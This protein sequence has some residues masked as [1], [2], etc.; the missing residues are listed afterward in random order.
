M[1][2]LPFNTIPLQVNNLLNYYKDRFCQGL[3]HNLMYNPTQYPNYARRNAKI[4][5]VAGFENGARYRQ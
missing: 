2:N 5:I 4:S 1:F 3:M